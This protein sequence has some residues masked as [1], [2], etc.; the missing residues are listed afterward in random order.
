MNFYEVGVYSESDASFEILDGYV[1]GSITQNSSQTY[2]FGFIKNPKIFEQIWTLK[3]REDAEWWNGITPLNIVT[4]FKEVI[5]VEGIKS[6]VGKEISFTL[7]NGFIKKDLFSQQGKNTQINQKL[8][9]EPSL[10]NS[11]YSFLLPLGLIIFF[12]Y[13]KKHYKA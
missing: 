12:L 3:V 8:S 2:N 1:K 9:S 11:V 7:I 10:D 5:E 13:L 6:Y 4:Y